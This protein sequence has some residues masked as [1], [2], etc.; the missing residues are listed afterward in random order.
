MLQGE[1]FIASSPADVIALLEEPPR[2]FMSIFVR[3]HMLAPAS[4]YRQLDPRKISDA[5]VGG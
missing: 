5:D 2:R 4:A 1:A 3:Q